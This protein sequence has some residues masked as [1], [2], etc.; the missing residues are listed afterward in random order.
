[1]GLRNNRWRYLRLEL[2]EPRLL[3]A[4]GLRT[5]LNANEGISNI[6]PMKCQRGASY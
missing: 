1:M 4:A 5:A 2:L 3:M 6:R